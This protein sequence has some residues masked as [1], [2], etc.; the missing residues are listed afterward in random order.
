MSSTRFTGR[1]QW[2]SASPKR[3]VT[4]YDDTEFAKYEQDQLQV[5]RDWYGLD[6][7]GVTL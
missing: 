6:E 2:D 1:S 5:D 4:T 3:G 7:S